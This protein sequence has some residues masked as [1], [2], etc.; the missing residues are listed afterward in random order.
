[1]QLLVVFRFSSVYFVSHLYVDE[2]CVSLFACVFRTFLHVVIAY[3]CA[4]LNIEDHFWIEFTID[5]I[6]CIHLFDAR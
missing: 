3:M 2:S 5:L 1:M 4:M 6:K